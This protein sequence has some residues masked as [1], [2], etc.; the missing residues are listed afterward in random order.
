[1]S[2][3]IKFFK[4]D[5]SPVLINPDF[6]QEVSGGEAGTVIV[7]KRE[8]QDGQYVKHIIPIPVSIAVEMISRADP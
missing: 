5:G 8:G 2:N 7:V 1:M 6:I 3:L 4:G